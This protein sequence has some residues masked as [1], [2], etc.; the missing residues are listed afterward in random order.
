MLIHALDEP[1]CTDSTT[2]SV[3]SGGVC[4]G[5]LTRLGSDALVATDLIQTVKDRAHVISKLI[6]RNVVISDY[7]AVWIYCASGHAL[8]LHYLG[9]RVIMPVRSCSRRLNPAS[10]YR[11]IAGLAVSTPR[12]AVLDIARGGHY[13]D[14]RNAG[15][16][17][18]VKY[19]DLMM[20]LIAQ[21][22]WLG[23]D[24]TA[25]WLNEDY[26]MVREAEKTPSIC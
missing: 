1:P 24:A 21:P 8:P 10:E 23:N 25:R 6:T 17:M 14:A 5:T 16:A 9:R 4:D 13:T 18:N 7:S 20:L 2:V 19:R 3:L 15:I 22:G 12:Q 11:D 26:A